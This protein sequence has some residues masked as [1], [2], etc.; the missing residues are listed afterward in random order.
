MNLIGSVQLP[1][2]LLDKALKPGHLSHHGCSHCADIML[3]ML[4]GEG[5]PGDPPISKGCPGMQPH[6]GP[7][8]GG[9]PQKRAVR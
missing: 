5:D 7:V 1:L 3:E 4:V 8:S 2:C 6:R 9:V